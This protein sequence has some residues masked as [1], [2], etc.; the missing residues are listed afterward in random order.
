MA[1][2]N[3]PSRA[4]LIRVKTGSMPTGMFLRRLIPGRHSPFLR[5]FGWHWVEPALY[6]VV[7]GACTLVAANAF[8]EARGTNLAWAD[9]ARRAL[10]PDSVERSLAPV[11]WSA[12]LDDVFIH[13]DFAR[14]WAKLHPFEWTPN[15]GYSSGATSWLYPLVLAAGVLMGF[16]GQRL[17][18][19]ADV[20]ACVSV[21]GLL[22]GLRALFEN[23][24][25]LTS[26]LAPLFVLAMG[27]LGWS[28]WSGMEL[29]LFLGIWGGA[30]H[31]FFELRSS[32]NRSDALAAARKLGIWG[33]L[34]VATRPE[35]VV[36]VVVFFLTAAWSGLGYVRER[37]SRSS[38]LWLT[39]PALVL[40]GTRL[41][42]NRLLTGSFADAGAL[43]KFETLHPFLDSR[44]IALR[45]LDNLK[46]ELVR[47]TSYH[48]ADSTAWGSL[49]WILAM[50]G[51]VQP[52]TRRN[53]ALLLAQAF[54]WMVVV[55]Q[56]EYVRYQNDR[57]TMAPLAWLTVAAALGVAGLLD[58][59]LRPPTAATVPRWLMATASA[60]ATLLF[61]Q[62]Q[63]PRLHQQ[64]WLFGRACKNIAEQQIRVGQ[65]LAAQHPRARRVLLSDAGAIPYFS[66]IPAVDAIGL[67][68]TRG[69]PFAAALR[70]GV[71]ATVE[72]IEHLR[73]EQRPDI[74]AL[75]PSWWGLLP[76]WFGQP[77]REVVI[78]GNVICGAA[79]KVI[80]TARWH[81]LRRHAL[82]SSLRSGE[83]VID[84]LDFGDVLSEQE[85]S[86]RL[87]SPHAGYVV[88]RIL[89]DPNS[90]DRDLFDAGRLVYPGV[91]NRFVLR[92]IRPRQ[93]LTLV[94]R[95]ASLDPIEFAVYAD[96]VRVGSLG[97]QGSD[98]WQESRI[99]IEA[100]R[101]RSN[102]VLDLVATRAGG[103][104]Y[105][106]WVVGPEPP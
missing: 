60:T 87:S 56:S 54:A 4:A 81:G 72:L 34:M 13:F 63:L 18:I 15:G 6:V 3:R 95:L 22:L 79:N 1:N 9:A 77:Y 47:I 105:H 62:H 99:D 8:F 10:A 100:G 92:S 41:A 82:P 65:L 91:H 61:L 52:K 50:L 85:H 71:G 51:L 67:G 78:S 88:S 101:V 11:R 24:S 64:I 30:T 2:P 90:S 59:A 83:G 38:L 25:R 43:V 106:L 44:E 66:Q 46:F 49:I 27:V 58:R 12:P 45:W 98:G 104:L 39:G 14:S 69:L 53:A 57:Y 32:A 84:E 76:V 21:F 5:R 31:A 70:L 19:W 40:E 68:G 86:Y 94:V 7:A 96:G 26:Y 73:P 55:A 28:L 102:M 16:D 80:Y 17:G 37:L 97:V 23:L 103:A 29:A 75:Y 48:A 33:L 42:L 35:A 36:C 93:S 74:F 89:P 20:I